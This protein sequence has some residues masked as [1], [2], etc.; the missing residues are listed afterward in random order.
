MRKLQFTYF[1]F[2]VQLAQHVGWG[3][4]GGGWLVQSGRGLLPL[5]LFIHTPLGVSQVVSYYTPLHSMRVLN[6][7]H[8]WAGWS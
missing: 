6:I 2:A 5:D 7:L 4:G 8:Q 1:L 3:W